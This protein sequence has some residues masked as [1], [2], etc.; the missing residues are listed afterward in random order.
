MHEDVEKVLER[1]RERERER[2]ILSRMRTIETFKYL[3][4]P[5]IQGY[6]K[7][8]LTSRKIGDFLEQNISP[9]ELL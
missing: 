8:T 6:C 2:E 7:C 1:E 4:T 5:N 9:L 3:A